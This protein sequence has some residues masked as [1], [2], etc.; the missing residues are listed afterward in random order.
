MGTRILYN[1]AVWDAATITS[2]SEAG[3][4]IDNNV[5]N[6]FLGKAW[7]TT[8]KTSEWIKFDLGSAKTLT[9]LAIVK[10]NLTSGATVKLQANATDS[11]G[12][13]SVDVTLTIPTD[14]DS[15][16]IQ[17]I[18]YYPSISAYR[19]YRITL[20]DTGNS[21]SYL[22]IG[23]IKGITSDQTYYSPT[24][25]VTDR[26]QIDYVDPSQGNDVEGTQSNII[27]RSI[28]RRATVNFTSFNQTQADKLRAIFAYVGKRKPFIIDFDPTSRPSKEALYCTLRTP[29]SVVYALVNQFNTGNLVMVEV[30]E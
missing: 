19:W 14:S 8:G 26:Y 22:Q 2:S 21:A 23:R 11:W 1:S 5:V 29:L 18:V 25:D 12:A 30:T 3:D 7:R 4:L 27:Q 6:D 10:F 13:P 24:R 20:V 17:Y 15:T 28:Y 16:V 9:A